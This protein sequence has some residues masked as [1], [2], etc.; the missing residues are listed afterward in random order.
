MPSPLLPARPVVRHN[1]VWL[2]RNKS[3]KH[4]SDIGEP[5]STHRPSGSLKDNARRV[6]Q[7]VDAFADIGNS[8]SS[9]DKLPTNPAGRRDE[10][11]CWAA[12]PRPAWSVSSVDLGF[13]NEQSFVEMLWRHPS[14][15][16]CKGPRTQREA[17]GIEGWVFLRV[18]GG[19]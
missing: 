18:W 8:I 12:D 4:L 2:G 9:T 13:G 16:M 15:P 10:R 5:P 17:M 7:K 19:I 1:D 14:L 11:R 6:E 3:R